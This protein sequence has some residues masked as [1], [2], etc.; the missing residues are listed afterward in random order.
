MFSSVFS[1][2]SKLIKFPL[3]S[4]RQQSIRNVAYFPYKI[5]LKKNKNLNTNCD[6]TN[7][8]L[9]KI[10][11]GELIEE[12]VRLRGDKSFVTYK[13]VVQDY[14]RKYINDSTSKSNHILFRKIMDNTLIEEISELDVQNYRLHNFEQTLHQRLLH[15]R[16]RHNESAEL[17]SEN[18][19]LMDRFGDLIEQ[20]LSQKL[21]NLFKY[22]TLDYVSYTEYD[23]LESKITE[24][25]NMHLDHHHQIQKIEYKMKYDKDINSN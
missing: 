19:E 16:L 22:L 14:F 18:R 15:N 17:K 9:K 6:K 3:V 10:E 25:K 20:N 8:L 12:L 21:Y 4:I 2:R 13:Y 7:L 11:S 1:L 23:V 5:D 24:L